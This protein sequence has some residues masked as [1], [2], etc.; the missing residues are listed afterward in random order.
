MM[1]G[2]IVH[3][4]A[5]WQKAD[6][7]SNT[8]ELKEHQF[9]VIWGTPNIFKRKMI[10]LNHNVFSVHRRISVDTAADLLFQNTLYSKLKDQNKEYSLPNALDMLNKHPELI[11]INNHV[12]QRKL[13]EH[14]QT[15][16]VI[17]S[18]PNLLEAVI[19]IAQFLIETQGWAIK[20]FT[21]NEIISKSL[22]K[23]NI[24]HQS[25]NKISKEQNIKS[26]N[27][28]VVKSEDN[29]TELTLSY[30][31]NNCCMGEIYKY[32]KKQLL[33]SVKEIVEVL[34]ESCQD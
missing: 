30:N 32:D 10:D 8:P 29:T 34:I 22:L 1:Q 17:I 9:P 24:N 3:T 33:N 23:Q 27:M 13:T 2:V 11:D 16:L 20:F 28:I 4:I 14:K 5:A 26:D 25:I 12:H 31:N 21:D 18:E 7:M 19:D 15:A 6:D